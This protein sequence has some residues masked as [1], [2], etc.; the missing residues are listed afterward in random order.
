MFSIQSK[1]TFSKRGGTNRVRPSRTAFIARSA[2]GL[3][4][5]NHWVLRRG[6][7]MS[8]LRWQRPMTISCGRASTRSPARI[9]VSEDAPAR[10]LSREPSVRARVRVQAPVV[11]HDVDA[12]QAVALAGLEVGRGRGRA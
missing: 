8:S 2:I 4:S 9:E 10:L 7:T 6:S 11:V 5:M 12:G 1:N 3:T